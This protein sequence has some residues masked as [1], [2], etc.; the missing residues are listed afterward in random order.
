MS[1]KNSPPVLGAALGLDDLETHRRW[2]LERQRDLEIQD[3]I[4][5]DV[6]RGDLEPVIRRARK[7]LDGHTGRIGIH[8]P[9]YGWSIDSEDP[10]VR[11]VVKRRLDVAL[12]ALGA[13]TAKTGG[14][15][16]VVHSPSSTWD[17][18]HY[19]FYARMRERQFERVHLCLKDAVKK[20]EGIGA[21]I[22]IENC[23]DID[24]RF[25]VDLAKSF[26]SPAVRVSLD[27]GHAHYAHYSTGG[28]PVDYFVN[29]AGPML[30]HVHLQDADGHA[31][32]HWVLGEGTVPW[33]AVF[34]ALDKLPEMPRLLIE[35]A[36]N[37]RI[38]E[39]A[40]WL[41]KQGLAV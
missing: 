27:T 31:D 7:L 8:G 39:A 14:G 1:R 26:E 19:D 5:I 6:I 32:R 17:Y 24:P 40:A 10:D 34:R 38:P 12:D 16:M 33:F 11:E 18:H 37:D 15:H 20:A 2:V 29:V 22:V 36:D 30:A 25:R 3:F 35:L 28:P 9:F 23:D 4:D 21:V 41:E 13:L